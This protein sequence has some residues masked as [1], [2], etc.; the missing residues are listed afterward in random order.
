[1]IKKSFVSKLYEPFL[2]HDIGHLNNEIFA[3][4]LFGI[5]LAVGDAAETLPAHPAH[6]LFEG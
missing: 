2:R 6:R 3:Y 1:M 4:A 5:S